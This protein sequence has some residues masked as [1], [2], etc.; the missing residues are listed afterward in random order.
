[1]VTLTFGMIEFGY[2][3]YCKNML[4]G[5]AREGVRAG[6][7]SGAVSSDVTTAVTNALATTNWSSHSYYTV[8]I[9]APT[10]N[11]AGAT[12]I[13]STL[14]SMAAGTQVQVSVYA[15]WGKP[16][17][18]IQSLPRLISSNKSMM[19]TCVMRKSPESSLA[20]A[21]RTTTIATGKG[22][23]VIRR[24]QRSTPWSNISDTV[25]G[26]ALAALIYFIVAMSA[27]VGMV[28][29]AVDLANVQTAKTQAQATADAAA[30]SM[31]PKAWSAEPPATVRG[32]AEAAAA[33]NK[34][35]GASVTLT[36]AD[37]V[38]GLVEPLSASA[39]H[40]GVDRIG[41]EWRD[42]RAGHSELHE[43]P[44]NAVIADVCVHSGVQER[45]YCS[46]CNCR[47]GY[48]DDV[49]GS[50]G[51]LAV[52]GGNAAWSDHCRHRRQSHPRQRDRQRRHRNSND[53]RN[54]I[55]FAAVG[56]SS[57][58]VA[59]PGQTGYASVEGDSGYIAAQA[60]VNGINTTLQPPL[61]AMMGIFLNDNQPSAPPAQR[62]GARFF[63]PRPAA[64]SQRSHRD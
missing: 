40:G 45:G 34:V 35:G 41:R 52:A 60:S 64:I 28:S 26:A 2:A 46:I 13:G 3:Y 47:P 56:G 11:P 9:T 55:R 10:A 18:R 59:G 50:C 31:P 37:I 38:F 44:R 61:N 8:K 62:G 32:R 36:D 6:I 39:T 25:V 22:I 57:T 1:M 48:G 49:D 30:P 14:G 12:D 15:T 27:M 21:G 33:D 16:G 19:G 42:R 58:W 4:A 54:P 23:L 20:N 51:G 5:A 17:Q 7:A 43:S 53:R 63:Q 29:L 24:S